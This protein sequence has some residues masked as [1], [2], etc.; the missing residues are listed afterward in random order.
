MLFIWYSHAM[1]LWGAPDHVTAI[2]L[3]F[4]TVFD[5]RSGMFS[6]DLFN[7]W[8]AVYEWLQYCPAITVH[9]P[10]PSGHRQE[11]E[12]RCKAF[13]FSSCD[14]DLLSESH[15]AHLS[16]PTACLFSQSPTV[17][18]HVCVHACRFKRN[19]AKSVKLTSQW[20]SGAVWFCP[21]TGIIRIFHHA[22]PFAW[23]LGMELGSSCFQEKNHMTIVLTLLGMSLSECE[24]EDP[25]GIWLWVLVEN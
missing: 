7:T 11:S 14:I 22:W 2:S 19:L 20:A 9:T 21:S 25:W 10:L 5:T 15:T 12:E 13:Y 1:V 3:A 18:V 16:L 6:H 17:C 23:V 8:A 24:V 4:R